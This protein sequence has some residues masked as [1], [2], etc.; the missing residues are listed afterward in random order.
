[1]ALRV[2]SLPATTSRMKNDASSAGLRSLPVD[3]RRDQRRRD[4]VARRAQ[5]IFAD[6]PHHVGEFGPGRQQGAD[7]L[8][9]LL[10]RHVFGV[11]EAQ[12]D[13]GALEDEPLLL[14]RYAHEV[15]DHPQRQ[16]GGDLR[17]KV[18]LAEGCDPRHD[19]GGNL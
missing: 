8:L 7:H 14:P 18:A 1:M 12:D 10:H 11:G 19:L 15:D 2:V 6:L 4:V 3:F 13:V 5:P 17:H 16:E 9:G